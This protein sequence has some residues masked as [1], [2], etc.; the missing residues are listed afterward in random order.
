VR[1]GGEASPRGKLRGLAVL[2]PDPYVAYSR[3]EPMMYD[4]GFSLR[5]GTATDP[6][7]TA[8]HARRTRT[9]AVLA[10]VGVGWFVLVVLALHA[11]RPEVDPMGRLL[12][13]YAGGPYGGL[14]PSAFVAVGLGSWALVA[15]MRS[16][17]TALGRAW[18]G[19][20][21][22]G[23][24]GVGAI[25]A[26]LR[27][28]GLID[29]AEGTYVVF[30]QGSFGSMLVGILLIA[31]AMKRDDRFQKCARRAFATFAVAL[32]LYAAM[33]AY[34]VPSGPAGLGQRLFVGVLLVW[35]LGVS[36]RLH[37]LARQEADALAA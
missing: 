12:S 33:F 9:R 29:V 32:S 7:L 34:F 17:A 2:T 10:L 23:L 20:L 28:A 24:W 6:F 14:L 19:H 31:L 13:A 16:T 1:G 35:L 36:T 18:A 11:L 4:P 30:A 5:M 37:A 25:V 26:G 8:A 22:L 21:A 15:A 27:A 3:S